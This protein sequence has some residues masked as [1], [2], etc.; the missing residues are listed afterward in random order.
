MRLLRFVV[1]CALVVAAFV[2]PAA[3]QAVGSVHYVSPSAVALL[4]MS[5]EQ[6]GYN[7]I[8]LAVS[9]S[10]PGDTIVV[11]DGVYSEKVTVPKSLSLL[12]SGNAVVQAPGTLAAGADLVEGSGAGTLVDM[13]GFLVRGPGPG[14]C[15][16]IGAGV[17]VDGGAT[18]DLSFSTIR[19]IRDNESGHLSGCQNGEG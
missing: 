4:D 7:T 16:S 11:C 8:Q 1:P 19:E 12:G 18:L 14:G 9:M 13:S 5:C 17:R 10:A 6:P 3:A 15:N 2:A